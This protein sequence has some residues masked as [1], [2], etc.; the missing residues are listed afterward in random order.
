MPSS[1]SARR[2]CRLRAHLAHP[3][4]PP[5]PPA[6]PV[7]AEH[8]ESLSD[9]MIPGLPDPAGAGAAAAAADEYA[10]ID[11]LEDAGEH[12]AALRAIDQLTAAAVAAAAAAPREAVPPELRAA[13]LW[14]AARAHERL[15]QAS[16]PRSARRAEHLRT[17]LKCT[18]DALACI[19]RMEGED[20]ASARAITVTTGKV[21]KWMAV[22]LGMEAN[23]GGVTASARNAAAINTHTRAALSRLPDDA[24]LHHMLGRLCFSCAGASWAEKAAAKI[25]GFKVPETTFPEAATHFRRAEKLAPTAANRLWL[26]KAYLRCAKARNRGH[27]QGETQRY[28]RLGRKWLTRAAKMECATAEDRNAQDEARRELRRGPRT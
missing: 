8:L 19:P 22:Y 18:K 25:V 4:S 14:R 6:P 15:W 21:H 7:A 26:G 16:R 20:A 27:N 13:L 10:A 12:E 1:Q 2:L 28:T 11:R 17:G 9:A 3:M 24:T 23:E 5:P